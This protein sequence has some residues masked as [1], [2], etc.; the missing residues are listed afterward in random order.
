MQVLGSI[1]APIPETEI[2][3]VDGETGKSL[4]KGTKGSIKIRG[5]QVMKGYYKVKLLFPNLAKSSKEV[6]FPM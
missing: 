2:K 3:V 1:G 5:P 4:P 6:P